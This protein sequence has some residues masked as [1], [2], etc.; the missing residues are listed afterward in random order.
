MNCH[1]RARL[2]F[3]EPARVTR[4]V[5][6]RAILADEEDHKRIIALAAAAAMSAN[7]GRRRSEV[8]GDPPHD[9]AAFVPEQSNDFRLVTA[10]IVNDGIRDPIFRNLVDQIVA[11]NL[12]FESTVTRQPE[13]IVCGNCTCCTGCTACLPTLPRPLC[14]QTGIVRG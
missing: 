14:T 2:L 5:N 6:I 10:Q 7:S 11:L 4:G 9:C 12:Q 13:C 1:A 8:V 3:R